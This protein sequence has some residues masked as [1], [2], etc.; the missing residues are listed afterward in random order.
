MNPSQPHQ[1]Y[2]RQYRH[3]KP[4][5]SPLRRYE[6]AKILWMVF[7]PEATPAEYQQTMKRIADEC[8]V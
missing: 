4:S 6:A 8:G 2:L 3:L 7:H 1:G 5:D